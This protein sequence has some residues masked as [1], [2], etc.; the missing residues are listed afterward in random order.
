MCG[1]SSTATCCAICSGRFDD[2]K[3][4]IF[5]HQH[6]DG[7]TQAEIA[8]VMGISEPAVRKTLQK[9]G[10]RLGA[11]LGEA[12]GAEGGAMSEHL[13]RLALDGQVA[14][15]ALE[16]A[17]LHVRGCESCTARI[18][19]LRDQ[20]PRVPGALSDARGAPLDTPRPGRERGG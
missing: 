8:Q 13:S 7:L 11:E 17:E 10:Q 14:N 5:V 3:V 12:A 16:G 15:I 4:Q 1:S 9:M 6:Y 20:D 2:R 19:R 18:A